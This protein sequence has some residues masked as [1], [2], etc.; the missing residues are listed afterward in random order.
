MK[1]CIVLE[2]KSKTSQICKDSSGNRKEVMGK[3]DKYVAHLLKDSAKK[4]DLTE[5]LKDK[6]NNILEDIEIDKPVALFLFMAVFKFLVQ[7]LMKH[8]ICTQGPEKIYQSR[9][10]WLKRKLADLRSYD[11]DTDPSMFL[12]FAAG[13]KVMNENVEA[14]LEMKIEESVINFAIVD[15]PRIDFYKKPTKEKP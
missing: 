7:D 11:P 14:A 4:D 15:I 8:Y 2:I 1:Y 13:I 6:T 3:V 9:I 5:K 10:D 12:K